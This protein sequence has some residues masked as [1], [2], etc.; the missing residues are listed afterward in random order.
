MKKS[1]NGLGVFCL[2]LVCLAVIGC[3][4][5][6]KIG[7]YTI[8]ELKEKDAVMLKVKNMNWCPKN[9]L[10]GDF[11]YT[12]YTV[13]YDGTI[14]IVDHYI[15][16]DAE[17]VRHNSAIDVT[18]DENV[19]LSD[20]DYITLICFLNDGFVDNLYIGPQACDGE[21]WHF[22]YYAPNGQLLQEYEGYTYDVEPLEKIQELLKAY[23]L[24]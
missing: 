20:E 21:G 4:K 23:S 11:D 19:K 15:Q 3:T 13:N 2:V 14:Q 17:G 9:T 12:S 16:E 10:E 18:G 6:K 5:G 7:G 1:K 8:N 24:D 22:Q